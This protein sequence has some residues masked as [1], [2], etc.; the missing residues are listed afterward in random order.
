MGYIMKSKGKSIHS[1]LGHKVAHGSTIYEYADRGM[2]HGTL[3]YHRLLGE[4]LIEAAD[5][6]S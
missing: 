1:L 3:E 4:G 2:V 5:F 6:E